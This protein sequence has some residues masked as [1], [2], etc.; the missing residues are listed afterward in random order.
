MECMLPHGIRL[1]DME[2][3]YGLRPSLSPSANLD[4]GAAVL[5]SF[6]A[7]AFLPSLVALHWTG[8]DN[9]RAYSGR[10]TLV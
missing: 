1:E 3:S 7:Y 6:R 2:T 5:H 8:A 9:I 4:F 10:A